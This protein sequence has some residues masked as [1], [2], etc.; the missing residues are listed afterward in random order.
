MRI[1]K[2]LNL[3]VPVETEAGTA[4]IHSVPLS[5]EVF[6]RYFLVIS[7]TFAEL[8]AQGLNF[9]AGPRVAA[10]LLK[11]V[12]QELDVWEG[13]GG[14]QNGL[15]AEIRRLSNVMV[16]TD[17]GWQAVMLDDAVR[18]GALTAEDMQEAEGVLVFF[19][20]ISAMHKRAEVGQFL[21]GMCELWGT[22]IC[23]S[24]FTEYRD[25]LQTSTATEISSET[26]KPSSL[27]G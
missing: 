2:A 6:E 25:S 5:R 24:S 14:V 23:S 3:V 13:E 21:T 16:P 4:Y 20:C 27:P 17:A 12:A 10:L 11:K 8:Y 7:K 18:R 26:V 1:D 15:M 9:L 22:Q 19:I